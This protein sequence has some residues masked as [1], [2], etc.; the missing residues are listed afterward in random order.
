MAATKEKEPLATGK[1]QVP[2]AASDK[3][4]QKE[5]APAPLDKFTRLELQEQ[6]EGSRVR[7]GKQAVQQRRSWDGLIITF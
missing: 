7:E 6:L 4:P 1:E 2:K 5:A 3:E